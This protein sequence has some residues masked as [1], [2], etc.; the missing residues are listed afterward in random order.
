MEKEK[1]EFTQTEEK[2][3]NI[4]RGRLY[5]LCPPLA[6]LVAF[7]CGIPLWL[8]INLRA[9]LELLFMLLKGIGML[10]EILWFLKISPLIVLIDGSLI[11]TLLEAK[12]QADI[13]GWTFKRT[14]H[15]WADY[16]FE[17]FSE[18]KSEQ[19]ALIKEDPVGY[20]L[21]A[22]VIILIAY[23]I[24][25]LSML[26]LADAYERYDTQNP[27]KA[28]SSA[29]KQ[30]KRKLKEDNDNR[31]FKHYLFDC[32][33]DP[34]RQFL[35]FFLF[36]WMEPFEEVTQRIGEFKQYKRLSEEDKDKLKND[37]K[38]ERAYEES[39]EERR[40]HDTNLEVE[41]KIAYPYVFKFI[42][43]NYEITAMSSKSLLP[44]SYLNI[45]KQEFESKNDV[46]F[47]YSYYH[48]F[49]R[50]LEK[51]HIVHPA[52]HPSEELLLGYCMSGNLE[53]G[54]D[55]KKWEERKKKEV[56]SFFAFQFGEVEM[57]N[58]FPTMWSDEILVRQ[59]YKTLQAKI[60]EWV[61]ENIYKYISSH[62][63]RYLSTDSTGRDIPA[64]DPSKDILAPD[65]NDA[66]KKAYKTFCKFLKKT[67]IKKGHKTL[68]EDDCCDVVYCHPNEANAFFLKIYDLENRDKGDYVLY[69]DYIA[70]KEWE[71]E[72]EKL[73]KSG[74]H[75]KNR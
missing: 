68:T 53:P 2:L 31:S 73:M 30:E 15:M 14:V 36:G 65:L 47:E 49:C 74:K 27:F 75:K 38:K 13:H 1:I 44:R 3:K 56:T 63:Q 6:Y 52:R 46:R 33:F 51:T 43:Y 5:S 37:A 55:W 24:H 28:I 18:I 22:L 23:G 50:Y 72:Q 21:L 48:D 17:H 58:F 34:L 32:F 9:L 67:Y 45:L 26:S 60:M 40:I 4:K 8:F 19:A 39:E 10:F 7:L 42:S 25:R 70:L 62:P 29:I 12:S 71:K 16:Y 57:L 69:E 11:L 54:G 61:I 64:Y 20:T 41:L 66:R 59:E 35:I